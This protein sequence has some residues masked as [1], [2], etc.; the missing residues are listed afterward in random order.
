[1]ADKSGVVLDDPK[2][3]VKLKLAGLWTSTMLDRK[4]VV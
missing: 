2:I 3:N 1:M 4:S